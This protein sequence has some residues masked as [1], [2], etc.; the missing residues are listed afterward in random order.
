MKTVPAALILGAMALA[1]PALGV[2]G[3]KIGTLQRG[4]YVCEM[5]GDA[6][7]RR[8][9]PVPEEG[10]EITNASTYRSPEGNGSYLRTGDRVAMTSGPMKGDRYMIKSERFLRKLASDGRESGLRCIK[11]GSTRD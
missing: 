7:T 5:P 10:F 2:T 11:L 1:A 9:V 3:G 4:T 8:G 6:A